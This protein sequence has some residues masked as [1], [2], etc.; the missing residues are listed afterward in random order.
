MRI[1]V[2]VFTFACTFAS[3]QNSVKEMKPTEVVQLNLSDEGAVQFQKDLE[4]L[5]AI[6]GKL[7]HGVKVDQLSDDEKR[8][9]NEADE[10]REDYWEIIGGGCSWYC[11]GGPKEVSASS[12]L[13]PQGAHSYEA[14]NAHDLSYRTAWVEGV[15]GYGIGQFLLYTFSPESPRITDIIVVN[16]YVKNEKAYLENSRAK[17][18][19]VYLNDQQF[20][21]LNLEDRR[22]TQRF[23]FDPI[24]NGDRENFAALKV[25]DEWTLKFEILEV[26]KGSK[27][28]DVAITE[29]YFD[30]IDVH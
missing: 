15:P 8:I 3:A 10:T 21:I 22:S 9:L 17:K 25:K 1:L 13:K 12:S 14:K 28:D 5:N 29:I 26:Y 16:G 23:K 30:G 24:G 2:A 19:K 4:K 18:I 7:M 11:G 6:S 20:A 27:Y